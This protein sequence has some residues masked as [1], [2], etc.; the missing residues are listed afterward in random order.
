MSILRLQNESRRELVEILNLTWPAEGSKGS[1]IAVVRTGV[2]FFFLIYDFSF[3]FYR[4]LL[5]F[6]FPFSVSLFLCFSS[7]L[8]FLFLFF[9]FFSFSLLLLLFLFL[10]LFLFYS[11][12]SLP[13]FCCPNYLIFFHFILFLSSCNE[14]FFSLNLL[15]LFLKKT[16]RFVNMFT[17]QNGIF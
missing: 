5:L 1:E 4:C 6:Y 10:F 12:F 17:S 9:L 14:R 8:F 16:F 13:F 2:H 7:C 11:Y 15:F 3:L